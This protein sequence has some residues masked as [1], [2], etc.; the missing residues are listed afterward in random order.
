V[1]IILTKKDT[2]LMEM[3]YEEAGNIIKRKSDTLWKDVLV[4]Y[5]KE[6]V[7][8]DISDGARAFARSNDQD[9]TSAINSVKSALTS[10]ENKREVMLYANHIK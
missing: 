6:D 2:L 7:E 1:K 9:M 8:L 5:C 3:T 4:R 10:L